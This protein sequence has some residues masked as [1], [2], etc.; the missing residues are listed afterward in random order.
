MENRVILILAPLA[1]TVVLQCSGC[2]TPVAATTRHG[3]PDKAANKAGD[4]AF[5][6]AVEH[7]DA[8][9]RLQDYDRAIYFYVQAM[10][11]H[12][13]DAPT[14]AKMGAI[15]D[16][17]GNTELSEKAFA[18][19]HVADPD[20]PH[21]AER[22]ARLYFRQGRID[23]AA[24][25]FDA[26]LSRDP[27]RARAL[28]G[29]GEVSMARSHFAEAVPYFDRALLGDRPDSAAILTHRG[30]AKLRLNDLT[31]AEADLRAA[32]ALA[33]SSDAAWRYLGDVQVRAGDTAMAM[34]SLLNVMDTAQAY[35]E[36]GVVLLGTNQYAIAR[37]YFSKAIKTSP[38]WFEEAQ[39]NL[40]VADE[41]L[42]GASG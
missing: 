7:G 18:L 24:E 38:A 1:L 42:H 33:P 23:N 22:L 21:I 26:V 8:A 40:A 28:D 35:N 5:D 31:A 37:E 6:D 14:L 32:L 2:A 25:L 3:L 41:H 11:L 19:A 17:R 13:H 29:M 30:C 4:K 12:P 10:N 15:E 27:H 34:T 9:W 39:R 20:E 16:A 36:I